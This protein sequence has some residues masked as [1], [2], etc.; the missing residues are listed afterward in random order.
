MERR[1][2]GMRYMSIRVYLGVHEPSELGDRPHVLFKRS[3]LQAEGLHRKRKR[4]KK[5]RAGNC[6]T[7]EPKKR[8]MIFET[9]R[10]KRQQGNLLS[11]RAR[12]ISRP[13][14]VETLLV[15]DKSMV[16]F[17]SDTDI[18]AYL[19]TIMNMVNSIY[20]D[21]SLGN[22]VH[23]AVVRI[24]LLEDDLDVLLEQELAHIDHKHN[25]HE[26]GDVKITDNP[27]GTSRSKRHI[28]LADKSNWN[29]GGYS[30]V[31]KKFCRWQ[32]LANTASDHHA[33]H[34]D[35]AVLVTR[36]SL[37]TGDANPSEK[38]NEDDGGSCSTLGVANVAGMCNPGK[39]CSVNQDNGIT[40][41]HTITH[42]LGHNFGMYHDDSATGGCTGRTGSTVHVMTPSFEADAVQVAWSKCSRRD[43]TNFLDQGLGKCLEDPPPQVYKFP[44]SPPGVL[45]DA[46]Q[47]CRMQFNLSSSTSN[48]TFS[49][50]PG[51][52]N[53]EGPVPC[54]PPDEI[55]SRLWCEFD[56]VCSTLLRPAAEGT[57]CGEGMWCQ[58]QQCVPKAPTPPAIHGSWGPWGSWTS[59]SR[60][61][62]DNQNQKEYTDL[63]PNICIGGIQSQSRECDSPKPKHG[64]RFCVGERTRYRVCTSQFCPEDSTSFRAEQCSS[65]NNES[66]HGK[67]YEWLPYFDK[68]DPCQLYCYDTS[69]TLLVSFGENVQDGTFCNPPTSDMCIS[70]VCRK[71]GCDMK[72]GSELRLDACGVCGGDGSS[73]D[74]VTGIFNV[75]RDV[76][77]QEVRIVGTVLENAT[78]IILRDDG[79]TSKILVVSN[80]QNTTKGFVDELKKKSLQGEYKVEGSIVFQERIAGANKLMLNGPLK[81]MIYVYLIQ[82]SVIEEILSPNSQ[83]TGVLYEYYV[84]KKGLH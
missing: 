55:C 70:G 15:A 77:T 68:N 83:N 38:V 69:D 52:S 30:N 79:E 43:I 57:T 71:V 7:K 12:S 59:C 80:E 1:I 33:L 31:L 24:V 81:K 28:A 4:K 20:Q 23:V 78:G 76:A 67:F 65:K 37:C 22:F 61:G 50:Q 21:P 10:I 18:E 60:G 45:Y 34:H 63:D 49:N 62:S 6:G 42:E 48:T 84:N 11:R 41:A 19:L 13:R 82:E 64:G 39:S 56:G 53:I 73:C 32:R 74:K 2:L 26:D 72:V 44:E 54:S 5:R 51:D 29:N 25:I 75:S 27:P 17:H 16:N 58:N 40:L 8:T 66:Y 3:T 47:Q 9:A 36:T 35:A 14:H 46:V